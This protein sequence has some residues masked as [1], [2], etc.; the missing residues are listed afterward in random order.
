MT[1]QILE[2]LKS[3]VAKAKG[4]MDSATELINGFKAKVDAAVAKALENGAT[5]EELE[6]LTALSA[7]IDTDAEELAAAVAANP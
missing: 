3:K 1:N 6:P 2:D 7:Q 4:A 5:S